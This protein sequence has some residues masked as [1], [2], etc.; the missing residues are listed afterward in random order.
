MPM[1]THREVATGLHS[2]TLKRSKDTPLSS[3]ALPFSQRHLKLP[4]FQLSLGIAV[5]ITL[6]CRIFST[7]APVFFSNAFVYSCGVL[8]LSQSRCWHGDGPII[9][10]YD[11]TFAI[12]EPNEE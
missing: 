2:N 5:T 3:P 1:L 9:S 7:F 10:I 4:Q 6:E 12:Q 11:R 8:R